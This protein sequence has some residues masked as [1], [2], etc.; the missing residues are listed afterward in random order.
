MIHRP[1]DRDVARTSYRLPIDRVTM[2]GCRRNW[3]QRINLTHLHAAGLRASSCACT[4]H[5]SQFRSSAE[6]RRDSTTSVPDP[7]QIQVKSSRILS[8]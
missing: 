8:G 4:V 1:A 2:A 7:L 3:Q 5:S 6:L